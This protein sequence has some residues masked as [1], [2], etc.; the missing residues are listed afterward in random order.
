[1][2][3]EIKTI[4]AID[5]GSRC[6]WA[7]L[8]DGIT[9]SGVMDFSLKRGESQGMVFVRFNAWFK[10]MIAH[11]LPE[12]VIYEQPHHRGGA[13]TQ[14]LYGMTTRIQERCDLCNIQYMA[15]HSA[16]LK[17]FATGSGRAGKEYMVERAWVKFGIRVKDHNEADAL[18]MMAW[19]KEEFEDAVRA[20]AL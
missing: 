12:V 3:K 20:E 17:K 11:H 14:L 18:W 8:E 10:K 1:M 19:G 2:D 4:L 7:L 16:T 9:E 15:I 13:A 5:P 6:G